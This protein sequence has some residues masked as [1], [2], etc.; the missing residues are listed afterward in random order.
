[1]GKH[2]STSTAI[3]VQHCAQKF[4]KKTICQAKSLRGT[5]CF[6]RLVRPLGTKPTTLQA[7]RMYRG[8][9][10]GLLAEEVNLPQRQPM[11]SE[12]ADREASNELFSTS[13]M[14][15]GSIQLR[16]PAASTRIRSGIVFL[17]VCVLVGLVAFLAG[18]RAQVATPI[19]AGTATATPAPTATPFPTFAPLSPR[20]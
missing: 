16:H 7:I 11:K 17:G 15:K 9:D 19:P 10:S 12:G 2:C 14:T 8:N 13:A 3:R 5:V 6:I 4:P 20:P 1:V 18:A